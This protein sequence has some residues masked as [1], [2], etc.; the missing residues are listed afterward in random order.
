MESLSII[1]WTAASLGVLHTII[2]PDHYLPFVMIGRAQK[3]SFA[4]LV[5]VTAA[6]G[7]GHVLSSIVLGLAGV[8]LGLAVGSL[9]SVEGLRGDLASWLLIAL[10]LAY[11]IWGLR[12][13]WRG[14]KHS[15]VHVHEDGSLHSHDHD[16]HAGH[17]HPHE[18]KSRVTMWWLFIVFVL[19][20]CEPLIPLIMFPAAR[21]SFSGV[22]L[23]AAVFGA[24][25]VTTMTVIASLLFAGVRLVPLGGLERYA[26][27]LAGF[28]IAASGLAIVVL[29]V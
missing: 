7:I 29:G 8:A 23:V 1:A 25:T 3:W 26:H 28:V 16:H 6:C 11:G 24:V 19:G 4:K 14:K 12:Q 2:G 15:H 13:A 21:H 10:G 27:A 17:A 5:A 9:E 20:P 22:V 18:G